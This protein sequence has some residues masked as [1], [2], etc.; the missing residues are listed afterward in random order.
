MGGVGV[1]NNTMT[2]ATLCI[3]TSNRIFGREKIGSDRKTDTV[4]VN[5]YYRYYRQLNLRHF[6]LKQFHDMTQNVDHY[7]R[8]INPPDH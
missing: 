4:R 8:D 6:A 7:G 1:R 5:I 3:E 2:R